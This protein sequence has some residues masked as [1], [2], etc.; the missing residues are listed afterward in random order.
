MPLWCWQPSFKP[1]NNSYQN[2]FQAKSHFKHTVLL[3]SGHRSN[4][5]EEGKKLNSKFQLLRYQKNVQE[6]EPLNTKPSTQVYSS[7]NNT[8][9]H[10]GGAWSES[11]PWHRLSW[12]R[13]SVISLSHSSQMIGLMP[14]HK[15]SPLPHKSFQ[16]HWYHYTESALF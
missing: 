10:S 15:L 13:I 16:V 4:W 1:T 12:L 9:L 3:P 11:W 8:D 2:Y 14:L 7:H 5:D 6:T